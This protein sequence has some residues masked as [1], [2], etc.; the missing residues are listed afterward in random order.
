MIL[1]IFAASLRATRVPGGGKEAEAL[2]RTVTHPVVPLG[3]FK[4]KFPL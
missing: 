1:A 2:E 3:I 4:M